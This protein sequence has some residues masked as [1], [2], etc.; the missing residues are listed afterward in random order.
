MWQQFFGNE[1][2]LL[3][4]SFWLGQLISFSHCQNNVFHSRQSL[5][6]GVYKLYRHKDVWTIHCMV[7]SSTWSEWNSTRSWNRWRGH[8]NLMSN[9]L[10]Y[11]HVLSKIFRSCFWMIYFFSKLL[12]LF[13][14]VKTYFKI[15][16]YTIIH[17]PT[18]P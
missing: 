18:Y 10:F 5:T 9:N 2:P 7:L 16:P 13:A 8:L 3:E 1:N 4:R 11:F 15:H 12:I 14:R 6:Q 17:F